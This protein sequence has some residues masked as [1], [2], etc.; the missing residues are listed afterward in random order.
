MEQETQKNNRLMKQ[1][2]YASLTVAVSLI[3][4]KAIAFFITGSVAIL[5]GLFD[6][7]QDLMTSGVNM[8]AIHQ[9]TEPDDKHHRFGHGKAQ[10]IGS[11]VQACIIFMAGAF[12][13]IE[14][15]KRFLNPEPL[16]QPI[17][18]VAVTLIAIGATLAL[19]KFQTYVVR[20]TNSLSIHADKAHYTGDVM[21][22]IG[23]LLSMLA[24]YYLNWLWVDS[25]FGIGVALY[26][27]VVVYQVLHASCEMLMDT[28]MSEDFRKEIKSIAHSCA[29]VHLVHDLKTRQSG[30]RAFV[31]FC[32]HLDG[33]LTLFEADEITDKME[34]QIRKRFPGTEVIIHPEPE[35]RKA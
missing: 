27:F 13:M 35:R 10:A 11:L 7:S 2:S 31:Q 4:L 23:I 24:A 32:V 30:D 28:E 33:N 34:A 22:N 26:L 29:R 6:S 17:W 19:V 21:M 5:S 1:A 20:K 3:I 16:E 9:A 25:V 14:A 12:L 8:F 18:G 15:V